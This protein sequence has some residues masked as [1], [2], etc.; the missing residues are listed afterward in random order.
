[1]SAE[2]PAERGAGPWG[3][4]LRRAWGIAV[5]AAGP[6][7]IVGSVL[8]VYHDLAFSGLVTN[9]HGDILSLVLP[10]YCLLGKSLAAG[11][12]LAWNPYTLSGVRF[13]GDPQ[14][15]W[16]YLPAMLLFSVMSCG[17]A[18]RWYIVLQP[19]LGGL[20]VYALLRSERAPRVAASLAGIAFAL[21]MT[22]S[23]IGL[24]LAVSSAMAWTAITLAALSR[25]LRASTWPA[26]IGWAAATA[27]A[28]GQLA[29][30]YMSTGL[31]MGSI[32]VVIFLVVRLVADAATRRRTPLAAAGAGGLLLGALVPVN[33]AVFLPRAS[34]LSHTTLGGGY[35]K[36][37]ALQHML[38]NAGQT[39]VH[40]AGSKPPWVLGFEHSPGSYLGAVVLFLSL[41]ALW[42]RRHRVLAVA[43]SLYGGALYLLSLHATAVWVFRHAHFVPRVDVYMHDP[44]RLRYGLVLPIAV[45]GGIGLAAWLERSA[46]WQRGVM[47]APGLVVFG[48]LPGVLDVPGRYTLLFVVGAF[49]SLALLAA[50]AWRPIV[51]VAVPA[52]VLGELLAGGFAGQ[53]TAYVDNGLGKFISP[54]GTFY[55]YQRPAIDAGAYMAPDPITRALAGRPDRF[56]TYDPKLAKATGY[57]KWQRPVYWGL[58][59]NGRSM[60]FHLYDVQGYNS[61]EPL[62]YWRL[63]RTL[64]PEK[65]AY[66]VTTLLHPSPRSMDLLG[67]GSV[68]GPAD[69]PPLGGL[70]P[71]VRDGM[72]ELYRR[73]DAAGMATFFTRWRTVSTDARASLAVAVPGFDPRTELVV[74]GYKQAQGTSA[75]TGPA[76]YRILGPQQVAADVDAPAAGLLLVRNP[77]D[78]NWHAT[79]DGAPA[80]V[81]PA[82]G[83]FQAIPVPA[84]RHTV[85]VSY[86]DPSVGEGLIGSVL[87]LLL[88]AA[89][90]VALSRRR[91][92]REEAASPEPEPAADEAGG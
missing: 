47:L 13:A 4:A 48:L 55:A 51:A 61:V 8:A 63:I 16:M 75:R 84:G 2:R 42:S 89:A 22:D 35:D 49:V 53:A 26:R 7:A 45:L 60:L 12:V 19:I 52:L 77:W 79:V 25:F 38:F 37:A 54:D 76:T 34:Y 62:R 86:D 65:V 10:Q 90:A 70:R 24:S 41:A 30:A 9:Q 66:N 40:P 28:W 67:I 72:W 87:V 23:Y 36:L 57:L 82:D 50:T 81:I 64:Q 18:I 17:R 68:V 74:E 88:L 69:A 78:Q 27:V 11:H 56:L 91:P 31:L 29:G 80:A 3:P 85:V 46:L 43:F 71:V 14:S 6:V 92:G 1:M 33:L 44:G 83:A 15:G 21:V 32:G 73:T 59:S 39:K 5:A 20:G 58:E